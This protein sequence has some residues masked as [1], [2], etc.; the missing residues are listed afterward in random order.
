LTQAERRNVRSGVRAHTLLDYLYRLRIKANYEDVAVFT[1][2]PG[3]SSTSRFVHRDLVNIVSAGV[4]VHEIH[5][6]GLIGDRQFRRMVDAWVKR[7][8]PDDLEIGVA[9]RRRA[10][11]ERS[12]QPKASPNW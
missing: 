8:I 2:G 6:R 5:V 12:D 10:I 11:Y 4:L 3:D 7:N 9:L 1:D